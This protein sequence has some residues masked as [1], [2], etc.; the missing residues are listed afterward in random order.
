[1]LQKSL[2]VLILFFAILFIGNT[3]DDISGDDFFELHT[4]GKNYTTTSN[5]IA[6]QHNCN[7]YS[8]I[9][10]FTRY[11]DLNTKTDECVS[12]ESPTPALNNIALWKGFKEEDSVS[13]QCDDNFPVVSVNTNTQNFISGDGTDNS[14]SIQVERKSYGTA[15]A[16]TMDNTFASRQ[17]STMSSKEQNVLLQTSS[18][19]ISP[20]N[21]SEDCL[22]AYI[23]EKEWRIPGL[24][25]RELTVEIAEKYPRVSFIKRSLIN[26]SWGIG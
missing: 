13:L 25:G 21:I 12:I 17:K 22:V 2:L 6:L 10:N 20:S 19:T 16:N 11:N 8:D 4:P 15:E 1:M 26:N 18:P 14:Y 5:K 24:E 7:I 9:L 3:N 23:P